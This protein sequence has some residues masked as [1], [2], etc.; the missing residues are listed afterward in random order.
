VNRHGRRGPSAIAIVAALLALLVVEPSTAGA[1]AGEA[2]IAITSVD[3][4]THPTVRLDF[5]APPAL[6]GAELDSADVVLTENGVDRP[7]SLQRTDARNLQVILAI[8][9]S[10]SMVGAPIDQAK[11]AAAS[12]VRRL[13]AG[14]EIAL[15][16]FGDTAQVRETFTGNTE[17]IQSAIE[18]I[19]VDPAAETAI[20]D[21]ILTAVREFTPTHEGPRYVVVVT[22]GGDTAS[23]ATLGRAQAAVAAAEIPILALSLVTSESDPDALSTLT[24]GGSGTLVE[25]GDPVA[26]T[27]LADDVATTIGAQYRIRYESVAQ[28]PTTIEVRIDRDGAVAVGRTAVDLPVPATVAPTPTVAPAAEPTERLAPTPVEAI[29]VDVAD[30]SW[31]LPVGV[32]LL[33]IAM[34]LCAGFL[35]WPSR[36]R[37]NPLKDLG[38]VRVRTAA[39]DSGNLLSGAS[40]SLV[41]RAE[42]VLSTSERAGVIT[43]RLERAGVRMRPA[44]FVVLMGCATIAAALMGITAGGPAVGFLLFFFVPIAIWTV[45]SVMGE[46]RADAFTEQLP[47]TLQMMGGALKAGFSL[48]QVVDLVS[49]EAAAPTC[50]EF[51]RLAVEESLGRDITDSF[52]DLAGRMQSPDFGWVAEAVDI[53]RAVGG[54]LADVFENVAE[55]IRARQSIAREIKTLS[56]EGRLS[57]IIL[58][59][60]PFIIAFGQ[61]LT[62]PDLSAELT[63]T[64]EGRALIVVGLVMITVGA[65]WMKRLTRLKF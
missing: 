24:S 38:A 47:A 36:R 25:A 11:Q 42:R 55:T 5:S 20:Y 46:R 37:R 12:F 59:S 45:L 39:R 63:S 43:Q 52:R 41:A 56:A 51:A 10:G 29:T 44:E 4:E 2:E 16:E 8:D 35:L 21:A 49:R 14:S 31:L 17:D 61:Y 48:S 64:S 58:I 65:L 7:F 53:N 28:G 34:A 27:A 57:A 6:G 33:G 30:R 50:D 54:D 19:A 32:A 22:D 23:E 40:R 9:T 60:V 1:Q 26:L 62:N 18:G 15:V 13:P 3:T